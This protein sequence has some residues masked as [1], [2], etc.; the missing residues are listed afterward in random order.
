MHELRC[1]LIQDRIFYEVRQQWNN[2]KKDMRS[3]AQISLLRVPYHYRSSISGGY[4]C[5]PNI[6]S[7]TSIHTQCMSTGC[8]YQQSKSHYKDHTLPISNI[9]L[10]NMILSMIAKHYAIYTSGTVILNRHVCNN[11][12]ISPLLNKQPMM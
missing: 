10:V 1:L 12:S 8:T 2:T 4:T 7:H 6:E 3:I 5:V 9:I 11:Q